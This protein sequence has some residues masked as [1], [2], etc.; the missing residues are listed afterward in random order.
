MKVLVWTTVT[1]GAE[2]WTLKLEE[3]KRIQAA[4]MWFHRRLLNMTYKDRK[5]NVSVLKDLNTERE[6]FGLV[7]KENCLTSGT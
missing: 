1:Y 3:K 5:T 2:G 7:V 4:E 6:L